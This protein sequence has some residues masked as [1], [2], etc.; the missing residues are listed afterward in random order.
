MTEAQYPLKVFLCHASADKARVRALYRYLVEQGVDPWFDEENLIGGQDWKV[1]I[2]K[3]LDASDAI[4]IC[5]S[6]NSI[7]K[8][9]Y[10]QR[11]IRFALD[12]ALEVPEGGT[13]L[14][15]VRF[16]ECKVPFSLSQ[17]QW[18]DIFGPA[19]HA[20]LMKALDFRA[21]QLDRSSVVVPRTTDS[22]DL[23]NSVVEEVGQ[24][25]IE[26]AVRAKINSDRAK[27]T[28]SKSWPVLVIALGTFALLMARALGLPVTISATPTVQSPA[29]TIVLT[30]TLAPTS[31]QAVATATQLPSLTP[32]R[33]P[34][35]TKT[36]PME[37]TD[38]K[39][40]AM[41]LVPAGEFTMGRDAAEA[42]EMPAHTVY[43]DSFYMDIYE[44]TNARYVAF[45]NAFARPTT[46]IR[47]GYPDFPVYTNWYDSQSYCEWRGARLPTEAEWEKA[48][49][50]TDDRTYPWG[51]GIDCSYANYWKC[52]GGTTKVGSYEKGISPYGIYDLAGNVAEWVADWFS[53]SYFQRSP[54]SNPLGPQTG[55]TKV[56]RGG[57]WY[58]SEDSLRV[59]SR[60]GN[61][62]NQGVDAFGFRCVR[63]P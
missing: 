23:K 12:K 58:F 57:A 7:N 22:I 19:G 20:R 49:R 24:A 50:G 48:A 32:N 55:E 46:G 26:Q 9:G 37:I 1:E 14:I 40:V 47:S 63:S 52:Q 61:D 17:F 15:P 62:P 13:F 27:E 25:A 42:K 18:V 53:E 44:V 3:A 2:P 39:G 10:V 35:P 51:E 30:E 43:V 60:F 36:L 33:E 29:S 31:T 45:L 28:L 21:S 16:E 38:A 11:E 34:T 59:S 8:A 41:R 56:R 4:I 5:M 54:F 6:K